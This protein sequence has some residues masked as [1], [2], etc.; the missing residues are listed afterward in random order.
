MPN[1]RASS[2]TTR[3]CV[4]R[5]T[6]R[7]WR[8]AGGTRYDALPSAVAKRSDIRR[9]CTCYIDSRL[10]QRQALAMVTALRLVETAAES[11]HYAYSRAPLAPL[12]YRLR[13]EVM[14]AMDA[15]I[16][17]LAALPSAFTLPLLR[18]RL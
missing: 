4:S 3:G 1:F 7:V 5:A 9:G 12:R 15:A 2:T 10:K 8:S 18:R 11:T 17:A 13:I 14:R 6:D 16:L